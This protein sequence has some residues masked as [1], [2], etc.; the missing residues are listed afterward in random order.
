MRPTVEYSL[1]AAAEEAGTS[2]TTPRTLPTDNVDQG[3]SGAQGVPR[4]RQ[5][6]S[7]GMKRLDFPSSTS[8]NTEEAPQSEDDDCEDDSSD[9]EGLGQEERR[10]EK[11]LLTK[12]GYSNA[13][14]IWEAFD[15]DSSRFSL[16]DKGMLRLLQ[17]GWRAF[18]NADDIRAPDL[19]TLK[20]ASVQQTAQHDL[21]IS[22]SLP[23]IRWRRKMQGGCK[24]EIHIEEHPNWID[25][26]KEWEE[27]RQK[28][29]EAKEK[30]AKEK[31]AKEKEAKEKE[32]K[33][34]EAKEK[35]AKEKEA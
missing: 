29:K 4:K 9:T 22:T 15:M 34:K 26:E 32:A 5:R 1:A 24:G 31:E 21:L 10:A 30:E 8:T 6:I 23:F 14:G 12:Y 13:K 18:E 11:E 35:E 25:G 33:E 17:R 7:G 28:E 20:E 2:T 3:F 16:Q 19:Q 27:R